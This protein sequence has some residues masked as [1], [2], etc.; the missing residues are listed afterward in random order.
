VLGTLKGSQVNIVKPSRGKPLQWMTMAL[1][2]ART[3]AR[4]SDTSALEEIAKAFHLGSI[5]YKME[6]YDISNLQGEA[7]AGSRVVFMDGE[8]DKTLY[9][10]YRIRTIVG[11]DDFAMLREVFER[12][13][14]HDETRPDLIVIDGGKGQLGVFQKVLEDL[15]VPKIPIISMAKAHGSKVDRFFLPGRKDAIRLPERS[16]GLRALQRLRDEAHRFA[17]RYHRRLRSKQTIS[18]FEGIPGIGPKKARS[19]LMH[20]STLTDLSQIKA[21]DL[22]GIKGLSG[23]DIRN[24]ISFFRRDE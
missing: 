9:R 21:E 22:E 13:L 17:V 15:G 11:Q 12:R 2:N 1:D 7:G 10:H 19:L 3:H 24:V 4:G 18:E 6:C 8:P 5:P 14:T 20:T 16:Q 23:K